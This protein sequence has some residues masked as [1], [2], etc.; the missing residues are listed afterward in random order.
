LG[1]C[2]R[3]AGGRRLA[4]ETW[5]DPR[6]SPIFL[7]HGTPG[8]RLGPRPR[9]HE[10]ALMG[11]RLI[12]YDRP[13]YGRS[14]RHVGRRVA[15]AAADVEA[16]ADA[17]GLDRFAVLGRSGGG[18]FALACAAL[19]PDRVTS[20]AALVS[21]APRSAEGLDWFAGMGTGNVREY[22]TAWRVS[23]DGHGSGVFSALAHLLS[24]HTESLIR[25]EFLHG[26][27]DEEV[28]DTDRAV[29]ADPGIRALLAENFVEAVGDERNLVAV[30]SSDEAARLLVGWLDDTLAHSRDWGFRPE[31]IA[32]PVLLWCGDVDRFTPVGHTRWLAG[33]I[34]GSTLVVEPGSGHFG[35]LSVLPSALQWLRSRA[36][37]ARFSA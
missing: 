24:Q 15:D 7:L 20:A 9:P 31:D 8:S 37:R 14:G 13:G 5:G 16:L 28:S 26:P 25:R 34:P 23:D 18:P 35:A 1:G 33:R 32:V 3:V 10:L 29:L 2:V 4:Y 30:S 27:L 11:I 36:P 21:F 12:A 19:L 17:L 22:A 6:G